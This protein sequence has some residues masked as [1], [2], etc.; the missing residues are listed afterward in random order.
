MRVRP[1]CRLTVAAQDEVAADT[2]GLLEDGGDHMPGERREQ[3]SALAVPSMSELEAKMQ[4]VERACVY[5]AEFI[6]PV[7]TIEERKVAEA[8]LEFREQ[9]RARAPPRAACRRW[10]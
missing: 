6:D 2:E 5:F 3:R 7:V 9:A 1:V 8:D 4:P 10:C